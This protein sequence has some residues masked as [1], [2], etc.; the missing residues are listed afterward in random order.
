MVRT[1]SAKGP[2]SSSVDEREVARLSATAEAWWDP[3]GPFRPLHKLNPVRLAYIRDRVCAH[4]GHDPFAH[5]PLA[6]LSLVDVGCGGGL[7]VEP[8]VRLGA[9]VTGID[10]AADNVEAAA[11][12]AHDS[13][14]SIDCRHTTAEALAE[15]GKRFHVL[16]AMEVVEH[17]ADRDVFLAACC[18]LLEPG[19][20]MVLSTLNRT[21]KAFAFAIVGAE[22]LLGWLPR[23]T[24]RWEKFVRPAELAR[25]LRR[26]GVRLTDVTGLAYDP[27]RDR[28]RLVP[29][30]AVN[31]L[32]TA[33]EA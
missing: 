25:G 26:H 24:H 19:G 32:A 8:M 4:F 13:G 12:H 17:V 29:D 33:V 11:R 16:L 9:T 10:A 18:R 28:W 14:L 1:Q 2:E 23:G 3:K 27:L 6:G 15:T 21:V 30:P 31:Y 20:V 5:R 22:Y 7:V